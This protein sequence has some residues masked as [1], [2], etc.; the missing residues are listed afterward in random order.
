[1]NHISQPKANTEDIALQ[2]YESKAINRGSLILNAYKLLPI[3]YIS[4]QEKQDPTSF[5][6][7]VNT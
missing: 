4:K 6:A 1:M 3:K 7:E 5:H 2:V